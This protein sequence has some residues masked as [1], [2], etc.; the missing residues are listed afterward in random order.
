M[1]EPTA[2]PQ[3]GLLVEQRAQQ[4]IGVQ[5][6]LH[7]C[8]GPPVMDQRAGPHCGG[9]GTVDVDHLHAGQIMTARMGQTVDRDG[10]TDQDRRDDA[11]LCGEHRARQ[12]V[13]LIRADHGG[14]KGGQGAGPVQQCF[15]MAMALHH[16]PRHMHIRAI[17]LFDRGDDLGLAG[18]DDA[19][20]GVP[21]LRAQPNAAIGL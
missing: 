7:H 11:V 18:Q 16:Q 8:C 2:D 10:V 15:E 4:I 9:G 14:D 1:G 19:T 5:M 17:E 6:A 12:G 3:A 13:F 20:I 21:H